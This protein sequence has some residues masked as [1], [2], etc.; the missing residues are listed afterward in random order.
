MQVQLFNKMQ[1]KKIFNI[2]SKLWFEIMIHLNKITIIFFIYY[3]KKMFIYI[4]F[5]TVEKLEYLFQVYIHILMKCLTSV[6][7]IC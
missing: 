1:Q 6:T 2:Y 7:N 4:N 5:K 3:Y